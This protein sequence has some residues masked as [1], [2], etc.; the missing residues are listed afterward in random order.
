MFP[1]GDVIMDRESGKWFVEQNALTSV[2]GCISPKLSKLEATGLA[3]P[4]TSF[5]TSFSAI[6]L[7]K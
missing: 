2:M 5:Q 7:G 6:C 1:F 3:L 4:I